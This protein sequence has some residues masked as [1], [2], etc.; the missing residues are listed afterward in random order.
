[1]PFLFPSLPYITYQLR[2]LPLTDLRHGSWHRDVT[3][4]GLRVICTIAPRSSEPQTSIIRLPVST[5]QSHLPVR[6]V[7]LRP[8][9]YFVHDRREYVVEFFALVR[10][11][12]ALE[13]KWV[14]NTYRVSAPVSY[15]SKLENRSCRWP[16][17]V[18]QSSPSESGSGP[19]RVVWCTMQ[20]L[21][22]SRFSI[23]SIDTW[24]YAQLSCTDTVFFSEL[25]YV[26]ALPVSS[27]LPLDTCCL[28]STFVARK[29]TSPAPQLVTHVLR[30]SVC[31]GAI[32]VN[33]L[34]YNSL[35]NS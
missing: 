19:R 15:P 12:R 20:N 14:R 32:G 3:V 21:K 6:C 13:I 1:M 34:G 27:S 30:W 17:A 4:T 5:R 35:I 9:V 10:R 33:F 2:R 28:V 16:A 29:I 25:D 7:V 31:F 8:S 18:G 11:V 23:K 22:R 24:I 26:C